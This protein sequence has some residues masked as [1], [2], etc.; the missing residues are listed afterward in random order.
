MLIVCQETFVLK[1]EINF[2]MYSFFENEV[3]ILCGSLQRGTKLE[4]KSSPQVEC[5]EDILSHRRIAY[6]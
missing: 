3:H 6:I 5:S 4:R 1:V 2:T